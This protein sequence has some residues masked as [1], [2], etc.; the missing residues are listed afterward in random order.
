[1]GSESRFS[2]ITYAENATLKIGLDEN[3]AFEQFAARLDTIQTINRGSFLDRGLEMAYRYTA[4]NRVDGRKQVVIVVTNGK[5]HPDANVDRDRLAIFARGLKNGMGG[6]IHW[7]EI[8]WK[9]I[10]G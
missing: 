1:M 5:S 7:V 3:M 4:Q 6:D 10:L 2:V 9:P 8:L